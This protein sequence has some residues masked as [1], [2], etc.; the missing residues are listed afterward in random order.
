MP[1]LE[2]AYIAT[3]LLEPAIPSRQMSASFFTKTARATV[4]SEVLCYIQPL[5][6]SALPADL[7]RRKKTVTTKSMPSAKRSSQQKSIRPGVYKAGPM[8]Q[9]PFKSAP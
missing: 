2:H 8:A 7:P 3:L 5:L 9:D 4:M 1:S 6:T